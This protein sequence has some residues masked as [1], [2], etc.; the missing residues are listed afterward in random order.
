L[1]ISLIKVGLVQLFSNVEISD[2]RAQIKAILDFQIKNEGIE[3][4]FGQKQLFCLARAILKDS[5]IYL[6][7]EATSNLD[8]E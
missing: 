5:K 1:K 2:R 8:E 3:L 6:I 4:S 7:D